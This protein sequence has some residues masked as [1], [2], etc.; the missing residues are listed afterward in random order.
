MTIEVYLEIG[1]KRTFAGAVEWPG[2]CRSGRDEASALQ[3]LLDYAPRYGR[4]V[5]TALLGFKPP[6][7]IAALVV[8]ERLKGGADTDFGTPGIAPSRDIEPVN[9]ADLK[10][11]Q[12]LLK[13]CW[14]AFDAIAASA[15]RKKL[16]TG[17]RGGGRD[18]EKMIGHVQAAEHAYVTRL[19][20][21]WKLQGDVDAEAS[22]SA[23]LE[24]THEAALKALAASALGELPERGP[25]GG[26]HW[27]PRYFVR[28]AAWHLLDH[29]WEI[30]DRL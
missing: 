27:S 15:K 5:H 20:W 6:K 12:S 7:G 25:R 18:L 21:N 14:N 30:E 16:R 4:A 3:S 19:G 24:R 28:R 26:L 1:A 2:W 23:Q 22:L 13:A 29:A 10:L 17:P 11:F 9:D 8:V